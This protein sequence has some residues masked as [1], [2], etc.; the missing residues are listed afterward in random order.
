MSSHKIKPFSAMKKIFAFA[1]LLLF[2]HFSF[3][4]TPAVEWVE[5]NSGGTYGASFIGIST[6]NDDF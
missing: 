1:F 4:Q 6:P 5:S 2:S 3:A